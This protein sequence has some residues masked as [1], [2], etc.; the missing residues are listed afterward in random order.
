MTRELYRLVREKRTRGRFEQA[1]EAGELTP[2]V[3]REEELKRLSAHWERAR[4]GEGAFVLVQ[5]E[6]GIGKS[7]LLRGLR[8]RIPLEEGMHLQVQCLPQFSGSALR[9]IIDLLLHVLKLD[10]EGNPQSNLRKF[11]GR[12]G[13]VGLPAEHVRSLAVLLSLPIVEES[14][15][16]RLSRSVGRRRRSRRW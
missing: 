14:P 8:E 12:M 9:P 1:H 6:A 3:G 16:L 15:H 7:R 5:G 11:Q 13:A 10:P 4:R 2:L